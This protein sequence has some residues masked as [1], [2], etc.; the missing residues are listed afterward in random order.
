MKIQEWVTSLWDGIYFDPNKLGVKEELY[1]S[2]ASFPLVTSLIDGC[3][4]VASW[5]NDTGLSKTETFFN[6]LRGL[7][8]R[9]GASWFYVTD[10]DNALS[11][12]HW[13]EQINPDYFNSSKLSVFE[14][15]PAEEGGT[16][17]LGIAF[18]DRRGMIIFECYNPFTITCYGTVEFVEA[19]KKCLQESA[20]VR[21]YN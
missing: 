5:S 3:G 1:K 10:P 21:R 7:V 14:K 11:I 9:Y 16:S 12:F 19:V 8:R 4:V 20:P 6:R 18:H 2:G 15:Y 17:Y 13:E